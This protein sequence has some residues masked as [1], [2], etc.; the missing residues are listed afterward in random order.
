MGTYI[1]EPGRR[2]RVSGAQTSDN[3]L[4]SQQ[5]GGY[6]RNMVFRGGH[7]RYSAEGWRDK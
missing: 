1:P 3:V 6:D 4:M 5:R 2:Y 7:S